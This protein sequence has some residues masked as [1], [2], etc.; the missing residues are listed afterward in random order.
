[1]LLLVSLLNLA[2]V[3]WSGKSDWW[4]WL[5]ISAFIAVILTLTAE[6]D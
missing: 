2:Y 3:H 4:W 1:M 5:G 6:C